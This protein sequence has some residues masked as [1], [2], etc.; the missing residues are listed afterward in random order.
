M[1]KKRKR[2]YEEDEDEDNNDYY[3]SEEESKGDYKPKKG[4]K[5]SKSND[6]I[7][8]LIQQNLLIFRIYR[9]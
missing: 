7:N 2:E 3:D 6:H 8:H 1:L 5:R 4:S 9:R